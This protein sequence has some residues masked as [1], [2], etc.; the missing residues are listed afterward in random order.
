MRQFVRQALV[1]ACLAGLASPAVAERVTVRVGYADLDLTDPEHVDVLNDRLVAALRE[2]CDRGLPNSRAA[3]QVK[4]DCVA[5]GLRSGE[6]VIAEHRD[7][8]LAA[9]P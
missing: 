6:E 3:L 1:A 5:S 8:A 4:H 7:R 2:A 9:T